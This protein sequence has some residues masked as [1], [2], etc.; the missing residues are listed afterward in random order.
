M[1]YCAH[2]LARKRRPGI[3]L[4]FFSFSQKT[5]SNKKRPL[6][7]KNLK[8]LLF[9]RTEN[10]KHYKVN[11]FMLRNPLETNMAK[12]ALFSA[13]LLSSITFPSNLQYLKFSEFI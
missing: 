7:H 9:G 12:D 13:L 6:G 3:G 2:C 11:F 10:K 1:P 8:S 5:L 4:A